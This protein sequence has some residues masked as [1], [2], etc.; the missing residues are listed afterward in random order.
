MLPR[1]EMKRKFLFF[2]ETGEF[3]M[4]VLI[5][6]N[7]WRTEREKGKAACKLLCLILPANVWE[8]TCRRILFFGRGGEEVPLQTAW[9]KPEL[10]QTP[11]HSFTDMTANREKKEKEMMKR[12]LQKWTSSTHAPSIKAKTN[13]RCGK[14]KC[15]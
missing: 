8:N 6:K 5:R 10:K 13:V 1:K 4:Q 3:F 2:P 14:V 15:A 7:A 12:I 11:P 9:H